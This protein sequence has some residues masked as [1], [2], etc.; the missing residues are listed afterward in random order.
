MI[1]GIDRSH[2]LVVATRV[3]DMHSGRVMRTQVEG[4]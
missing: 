1:P 2:A 4:A 3:W